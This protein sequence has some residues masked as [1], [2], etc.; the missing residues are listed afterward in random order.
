LPSRQALERLQR[1]LPQSRAAADDGISIEALSLST[2]ISDCSFATVSPGFT[3]TSITSTSLKSPMSGTTTSI[4]P[5]EAVAGA[6]AGAGA[7]AGAGADFGGGALVA[8]GGGAAAGAP[9]AESSTTTGLPCETLSPSF[10]RS[11][12]TTPA[13]DDGISIDALS[14]STVISDCSF[15]TVSPGFTSTSITSTSLKSPM[16]GT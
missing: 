5:P 7:G 16:S 10:T 14:L 1:P 9:E 3:S 6:D 11:S 4:G 13:D 8:A 15:A 12:F 2:V